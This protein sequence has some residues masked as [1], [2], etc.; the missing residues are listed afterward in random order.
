MKLLK[1]AICILM[2]MSIFTNSMFANKCVS[3]E[4]AAR[5]GLVKLSIKSRGGFTGEVIE[6]NIQNNTNQKLDLNV[7]AG[8]RLDSKNNTEQD[9]LVTRSQEFFVNG[10]QSKTLKVYGMCCQAHN[11]S[12]KVNSIYNVGKLADSNL[13]KLANFI[14][15]NKYYK[16]GAAQDAVWSISNKNSSSGFI[17]FQQ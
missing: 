8:R 16:D 13:V 15:K 7:E 10:K 5:K 2:A 6:M 3:V 17:H 4:E 11:S 1:S 14:D 9:I 12:P